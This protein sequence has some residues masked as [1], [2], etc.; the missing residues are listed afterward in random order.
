MYI[1]TYIHTFTNYYIY[2][3]PHSDNSAIKHREY[4]VEYYKGDEHPS[5]EAFFQGSDEADSDD[6]EGGFGPTK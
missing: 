5:R 2:I 4:E 3:P 6:E 1:H